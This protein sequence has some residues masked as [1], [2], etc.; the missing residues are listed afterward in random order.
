MVGYPLTGLLKEARPNT[1]A[2][3]VTFLVIEKKK[4]L[5]KVFLR[6]RALQKGLMMNLRDLMFFLYHMVTFLSWT[7]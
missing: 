5:K 7:S 1:A 6:A 3:F 4:G 2:Y